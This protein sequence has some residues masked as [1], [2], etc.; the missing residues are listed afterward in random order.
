MFYL[1]FFSTDINE[2]QS[3]NGGCD[4]KCLNSYGS[5]KCACDKGY[6]YNKQTNRCNG[7]YTLFLPFSSF[8]QLLV[9]LHYLGTNIFL[10][11]YFTLVLNK[12]QKINLWIWGSYS[13]SRSSHLETFCWKGVLKICWKFAAEHPLCP[14]RISIKLR[15]NL[16]EITLWQGCSP[17]NL[18]HI[19][20]IPFPR[21]ISGRLLL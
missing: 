8:L 1:N 10:I 9:L 6:I 18:L 14:S 2:C 16:I 21:N 12:S 15:R 7:K 11:L 19:F 13:R 5:Y 4:Q 3:N 20:R 17:G